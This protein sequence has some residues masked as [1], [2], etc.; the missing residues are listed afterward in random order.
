MIIIEFML[1]VTKSNDIVER[2]IFTANGPCWKKQK[3]S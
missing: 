3:K 2:E 1:K